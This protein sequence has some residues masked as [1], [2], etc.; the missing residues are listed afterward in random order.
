MSDH[1]DLAAELDAALA[2]ASEIVRREFAQKHKDDLFG[3]QPETALVRPRRLDSVHSVR[4]DADL[5]AAV[6]ARAQATGESVSDVIRRAAQH[7]RP[8][9]YACQHYAMTSMPGVLTSAEASCGCDMQPVYAA[10]SG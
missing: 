2:R 6:R 7:A 4:M 9:G 5:A 8:V 1:E 10:A 3:D